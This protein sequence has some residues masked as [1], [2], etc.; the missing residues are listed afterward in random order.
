MYLKIVEMIEAHKT[1][2]VFKDVSIYSCP[3][4][5]TDFIIS[6]QTTDPVIRKFG[7]SLDMDTYKKYQSS[8]YSYQYLQDKGCYDL[9][10]SNTFLDTQF[11][12]KYLHMSN[13]VVPNIKFIN[14]SFIY[15]KIE[16]RSNIFV[17]CYWSKP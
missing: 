7:N 17:D 14:C 11:I 6:E 12:V 15:P 13:V 16:E 4:K 9:I 8:M 10:V 2:A 5:I 1:G 3:G